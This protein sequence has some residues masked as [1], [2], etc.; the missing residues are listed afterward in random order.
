[1]RQPAGLSHPSTL[2]RLSI[3]ADLRHAVRLAT[4]SPLVTITSVASIALG[5]AAAAT[6]FSVADALLLR[7]GHGVRNS[8]QV[9]DIARTTNGTGYGTMSY[10]AFQHLRNHNQS[11]AAMAATTMDPSPLSLSAGAGTTRVFGRT[12]SAGF[13]DLVG[14]KPVLG[15]FFRAEEDV[16]AE[17]QPVTVLTHRFWLDHFSADPS[18]VGRTLQL[19]GSPFTVVGVAE[20]GFNGTSIVGT[21]LWV[22]MAMAG[23][24]RG[25]P[26]ASLLDDTRATWHVAVGRLKPG[27]TRAAA[28]AE[29][30]VLLNNFDAD[31]AAPQTRHGIVVFDT[32]RLPPP[33]RAR[34]GSFLAFLLALAGGLL[35]IACSNVA[36]MLIARATTRHREIATRLALGA[37]RGRLLQMMLAETLVLYLV[38][39]VVALPATYVLLGAFGALLPALPL[40][41]DLDLAVSWRTVAFAAGVS[42]VTAVVFGLAP[43]RHAVTADLS[44]LLHGRSSTD[45]NSR[46]RLRHA[47]LVAQVALSLVLIFTAGLFTR[48]LDAAAAID[49]GFDAANVDI[50]SLDANVAGLTGAD[51]AAAIER[52]ADRAAAVDGVE[53]VAYARMVPLFSGGFAS[54]SIRLPGR[55]DEDNAAFRYTQWDLV[56]PD[57]FRTLRMPI[58]RGRSFTNNDR[59]G[60]PLVAVVNETFAHR[61][62]PGQD[63]IGQQFMQ[64]QAGASEGETTA[65]QIEVVGVSKDAKYQV[66]DEPAKPFVY[67]PFG[68]HPQTH[69]ELFVK[70][71][72]SRSVLRDVRA[73]IGHA[74]PDLPIVSGQRFDDAI[75]GGLFPQRLAAWTAGFVGATG[76]LLAGLGLYG[77]IAFLVAQR[78]R[79]IAIRMA[80]GARP[81]Q[82]GWLVLKR[83]VRVTGIGAAVGLAVA[84]GI[85]R[86]L[87]NTGL[88][89][90][91]SAIDP[92]ALAS[93]G[94]LMS[95]AL[96]TAGYVPARRA[97]STDPASALRG[98]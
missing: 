9:V 89:M 68:Q 12:V 90:G 22:P 82:V 79:E 39:V 73:A 19:N 28:E 76:L 8:A 13:F 56:S 74:A 48:A 53:S 32:G 36:G 18:V 31:T 40:P 34:F 7:P 71:A 63:A 27:V 33:V 69:V 47:L 92:T 87:Q 14:A 4:R 54:G 65:R 94:L 62:W 64:V 42:L 16:A 97:T 75:A 17:G 44:P 6:I 15:R 43:A 59:D 85:G 29:L 37:S 55:S 80:L 1:M 57:Y 3:L 78:V 77:L 72:A 10:P 88:L 67:V 49:I 38:A 95:G 50:I 52:I 83:A 5:V 45:S 86:I 58:V 23:V 46:L 35:A 60:S 91:V 93:V 2:A 61:A 26:A 25:V 96:L 41:M 81:R 24:V 20:E 11:L 51:A 98:D 84:I 21:D 30:N 70:H 66:I